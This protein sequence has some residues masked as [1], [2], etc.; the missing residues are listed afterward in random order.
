[1][2]DLN[3]VMARGRAADRILTDPVFEEAF[4]ATREDYI[5]TMIAAPDDTTLR[6]AKRNLDVLDTVMAKLQGYLEDGTR[7]AKELANQK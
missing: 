3:A 7:A 4:S 1:M 6:D 2:N 5:N